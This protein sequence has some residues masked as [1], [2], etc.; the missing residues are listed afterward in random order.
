MKSIFTKNK[1][2]IA[3]I[4]LISG[5]GLLFIWPLP[6]TIALRNLLLLTGGL[7]SIYFFSRDRV[8]LRA[9]VTANFPLILF[10]F[11]VVAHYFFL[12]NQ[13]EMQWKELTGFW[14]RSAIST[15]MGACIGIILSTQLLRKDKKI[16]IDSTS[17]FNASI[18]TSL[19]IYLVR[20][21][22]ELAIS[23]EPVP[24]DFY[25][26]PFGGKPQIVIFIGIAFVGG[27]T[28]LLLALKTPDWKKNIVFPALVMGLSLFSFQLSNTKNGFL[29]SL[30]LLIGTLALT[31]KSRYYAPK[32][33][34]AILIASVPLMIIGGIH[35]Q[36]NT[37]WH[38]AYADIKTGVAISE[39]T[40]WKD[41]LRDPL[42]RNEN[43]QLVNQST[44][45]RVAWLTAALQIIGD[46]PWGYGL[47]SYSFTYLAQEK[48][49]DFYIKDKNH[50]VAT[51]SGWI[52]LTLGL[53]IPATAFLFFSFFINTKKALKQENGTIF[54]NKYS[55]LMTP[56]F[57]LS[58]LTVEVSYDIFYEVLLFFLAIFGSLQSCTTLQTNRANSE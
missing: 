56:F 37:A 45:L 40:Y 36:K 48:W 13:K 11:W 39:Q 15:I 57:L 2:F 55:I 49:S 31:L 34:S 17:I 3:G 44:Y 22:Y 47:M 54:W 30:S 35:I 8:A 46:H 23:K 42:P 43:D 26:I 25:M 50:M 21:L 28:N 7:S 24:H 1:E 10:F 14:L 29:V 32:I 19:A 53:G 20:Y 5:A 38:T 6:G 33:K 27:L 18:Y 16:H 52:D 58:F 51:H 41:W 12:S 9:A 4:V